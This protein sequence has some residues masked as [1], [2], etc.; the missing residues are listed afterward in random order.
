MRK[1]KSAE[2]AMPANAAPAGKPALPPSLANVN[3]KHYTEVQFWHE[4]IALEPVLG[5]LSSADPLSIN[6]GGHQ[7]RLPCASALRTP[8]ASRASRHQSPPPHRATLC[9]LCL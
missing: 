1:R 9:H 4:Q 7:A 8:I 3:T 2:A 6:D 5:D